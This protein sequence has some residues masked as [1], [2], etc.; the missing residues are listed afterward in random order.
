MLDN[1]D[2]HPPLLALV[3]SGGHTELIHLPKLGRYEVWGRTR[4]D[5]AGEAFDK[6][7]K[8]L[9]LLKEGQ[10]TMGGPVV[11]ALAEEGESKAFDFPRALLGAP[12]Y[13]FSFSGLKTS[14]LYHLRSRSE[15]EREAER[16]DVAASFQAAAVDVL[17]HKAVGA[18]QA[19]GAE[20]LLVTG[21]VAANGRLREEMAR[22]CA[23]V[24][25]RLFLP[26]LGL[27][28]DNGAMI[29]GA[30]SFRLA[31]GERSGWDLN[32][33]PGMVLPGSIACRAGGGAA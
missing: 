31:R 1:P 20:R 28:T 23:A 2:L 33:D 8:M 18:A 24:G 16:A 25:V 11:S 5:A 15:A 13:E 21:G 12:G 10:T 32:A 27:C 14:V 17:V 4:D 19:A 22:A 30:G 6:V 9:G 26:S 29:A 3:V 7:A